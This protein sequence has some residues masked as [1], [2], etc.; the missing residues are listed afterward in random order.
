MSTFNKGILG[1]FSGKVGNVVGSSWKGINVM[2]SLPASVKQSK[3][4]RALHNRARFAK[5]IRFLTK[6][7]RLIPLGFYPEAVK[8]TSYNAAFSHNFPHI[9]FDGEVLKVNFPKLMVSNGT[10]DDLIDLS[11]V[12]DSDQMVMMTW[13]PVAGEVAK[14]CGVHFLVL[15]DDMEYS[16]VLTNVATADKGSASFRVSKKLASGKIHIYA[17]YTNDLDEGSDAIS[18]CAYALVEA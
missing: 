1:G 5:T 12:R 14:H 6:A 13:T 15:S 2:R 4:V 7:N 16:A 8:Q 9:D 11:A 3:S 10:M 18:D 17:F